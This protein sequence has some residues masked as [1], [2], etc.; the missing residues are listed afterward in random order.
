MGRWGDGEMGR[1]G[2]GEVGRWGGGEMG[3]WGDG[4]VGRWPDGEVG[5]WPDEGQSNS[6]FHAQF[7]IRQREQIADRGSLGRSYAG[8]SIPGLP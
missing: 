3:R 8:C 1:W 4:E 7:S 5:R 2:G 6:S